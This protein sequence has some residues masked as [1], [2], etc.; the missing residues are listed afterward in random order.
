MNTGHKMVF[1][2]K[3][4]G[5]NLKFTAFFRNSFLEHLALE[6]AGNFRAVSRGTEIPIL[7]KGLM[8]DAV[9]PD[10][11]PVHLNGTE[12]QKRVWRETRNIPYGETTTYGELAERVKC[13]S[14]RAVG[15]ALGENPLPVIIPCHRVIGKNGKLTGFSCGLDI[16]WL[17]L[18]HEGVSIHDDCSSLRHP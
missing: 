16:K 9:D 4:R 12:F 2:M 13:G 5:G 15:H 6:K 10:L 14:P 3:L 17:L 11:I 7:I 18:E 1:Y 8:N